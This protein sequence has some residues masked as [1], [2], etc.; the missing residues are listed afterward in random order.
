MAKDSIKNS[1]KVN[2]QKKTTKL[3]RGDKLAIALKK[4]IKLR[5]ENKKII[6]R[7]LIERKDF[8]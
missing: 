3:T 2:Y 6:D 7:N 8:Y 1:E 4:N 5:K